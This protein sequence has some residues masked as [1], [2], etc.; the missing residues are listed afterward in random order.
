MKVVELFGQTSDKAPVENK[1]MIATE[2][3]LELAKEG[4]IEDLVIIGSNEDGDFRIVTSPLEAATAHY[5]LAQA[6]QFVL[7]G[8]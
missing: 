2:I 5:M 7:Q 4:G 6:Q 8:G 3:L 1:E